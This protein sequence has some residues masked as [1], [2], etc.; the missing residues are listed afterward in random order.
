ML[1][2][3]CSVAILSVNDID[4]DSETC[5]NLSAVALIDTDSDNETSNCFVTVSV[6]DIDSEIFWVTSLDVI[7]VVS[8]NEMDSDIDTELEAEST[9]TPFQNR[10]TNPPALQSVTEWELPLPDTVQFVAFSHASIP[11]ARSSLPVSYTHLTLP[12]ILLV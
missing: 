1:L 11:T 10:M 8:V 5:L 6:S 12:T 3:T 2:T 4:S 7:A 9:V